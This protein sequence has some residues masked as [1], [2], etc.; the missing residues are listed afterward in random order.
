MNTD[1]KVKN[2]YFRNAVGPLMSPGNHFRMPRVDKAVCRSE[3]CIRSDGYFRIC[4]VCNVSVIS[5]F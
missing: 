1:Y 5:G 2:L 3:D 4:Y